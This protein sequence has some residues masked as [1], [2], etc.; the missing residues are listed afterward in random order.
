MLGLEQQSS[1]SSQRVSATDVPDSDHE[2]V[3]WRQQLQSRSEEAG[4]VENT[5]SKPRQAGRDHG[6]ICLKTLSEDGQ[7][8][9]ANQTFRPSWRETEP[10]MGGTVDEFS[11]WL[12]SNHQWMGAWEKGIPRTIEGCEN[13]LHRLKGLGNAQVPLCAATAWRILYERIKR[14]T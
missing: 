11:R 12:D 5:D 14:E 13:R 7:K 2:R 10:R 9:P 4:N 8:R 6:K 1:E 3:E